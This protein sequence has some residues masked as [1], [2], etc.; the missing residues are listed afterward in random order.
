MQP[1]TSRV[2]RLHNKV[3]LTTYSHLNTK[4]IQ[5]AHASKITVE[6]NVKQVVM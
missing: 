2:A 5:A 6:P 1:G 3:T 4:S